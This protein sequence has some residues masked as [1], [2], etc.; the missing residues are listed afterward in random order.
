[1][2]AQ[3]QK[4]E[5]KYSSVIH[6]LANTAFEISNYLQN[7][8]VFSSAL[9]LFSVSEEFMVIFLLYIL[10]GQFHLYC[11]RH[12]NLNLARE[13]IPLYLKS[14]IPRALYFHC[15]CWQEEF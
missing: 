2:L 1:M 4:T 12:L 14:D 10:K 15:I 13:I 11:F 8:K 9:V 7:F 6:C 3:R 5:E